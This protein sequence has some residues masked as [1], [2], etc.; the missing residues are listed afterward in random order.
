MHC[1]VQDCID[2]FH[3]H[4]KVNQIV[5]RMWFFS[6]FDDVFIMNSKGV[7]FKWY[8][9]LLTKL[10]KSKISEQQYEVLAQ[11]SFKQGW[12]YLS[13]SW[14]WLRYLE[15]YRLIKVSRWWFNTLKIIETKTQIVNKAYNCC[16]CFCF[17]L[18]LEKKKHK[19]EFKDLDNKVIEQK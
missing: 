4:L 12:W 10:C 18:L 14:R 6:R 19:I 16:A 1:K 8:E 15:I 7:C 17:K 13:S 3:S 2:K 11:C 5:E 9:L